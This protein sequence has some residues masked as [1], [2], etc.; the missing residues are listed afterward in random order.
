MILRAMGATKPGSQGERAI[1]RKTIA[2]GMPDDLAEPVV[3]A[4]SF[5]YCWRAMGEA[6]TRHSLRP[7]FTR[8]GQTPSIPRGH[9]PARTLA[10]VLLPEEATTKMSE[11]PSDT[12]RASCRICRSHPLGDLGALL[13]LD[14]ADIVLAL[15]VQPELRAVA[16]M[17]AEP[18]GGVGRDGPAPARGCR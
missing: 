5:S 11:S 6:F 10:H 18:H 4:A 15:Q 9:Q 16:K 17:A 2:Q 12:H 7:L 1:R 14:H 8:E 13:A 3:T